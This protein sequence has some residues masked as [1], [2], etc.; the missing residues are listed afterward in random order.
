MC[1]HRLSPCDIILCPMTIMCYYKS[2]KLSICLYMKSGNYYWDY[3]INIW[4]CISNFISKAC[5]D[6]L[7]LLNE[8][9]NVITGKLCIGSD[10]INQMTL[11]H[12]QTFIRF[13]L[14]LSVLGQCFGSFMH[15]HSN[16]VLP[17]S[18]VLKT[19]YGLSPEP[20]LLLQLY[21]ISLHAEKAGCTSC[22]YICI[23]IHL[24]TNPGGYRPLNG[25]RAKGTIHEC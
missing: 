19:S 21:K 18:S 25:T 20:E 4:Q 9:H 22:W 10:I 6:R 14:C 12:S 8:C 3:H 13:N 11:N 15:A 24:L 1:S 17:T 16:E 5:H 7:C 2:I 23:F